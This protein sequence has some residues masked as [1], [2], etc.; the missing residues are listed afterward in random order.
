[1][2]ALH[3]QHN[4]DGLSL[5]VPLEPPKAAAAGT[6]AA[7][8]PRRSDAPKSKA[9]WRSLPRAEAPRILG[10]PTTAPLGP[11]LIKLL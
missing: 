7:A 8:A 3:T 9:S 1:M 4:R 10:S 5:L 2:E 6:R 11:P